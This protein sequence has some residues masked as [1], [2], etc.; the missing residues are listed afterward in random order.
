MVKG[1]VARMSGRGGKEGAV[2][3]IGQLVPESLAFPGEPSMFTLCDLH[4]I[5]IVLLSW[6]LNQ[7]NEGMDSASGK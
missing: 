3:G 4:S 6:N 2:S 1:W 7:G 5:W